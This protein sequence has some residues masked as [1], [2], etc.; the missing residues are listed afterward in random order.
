MSIG[1]RFKELRLLNKET[2]ISFSAKLKVDN[3]QYGKIESDMLQPTLSQIMELS[4]IFPALNIN[5]LLKGDGPM[6]ITNQEAQACDCKE[7]IE[8]NRT[9]YK[10]ISQ[11]KSLIIQMQKEALDIKKTPDK[12]HRSAPS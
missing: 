3:S 10:E 11:L 1:L 8:E 4:S 7:Y 12:K 5:W 9:L 2:K 6:L